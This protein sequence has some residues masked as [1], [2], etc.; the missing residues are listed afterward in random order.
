MCKES[1]MPTKCW[2]ECLDGRD[3]LKIIGTTGIIVPNRMR[4]GE[5]VWAEFTR[6]VIMY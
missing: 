3:L 4:W 1:E 6:L 2:S 5:G